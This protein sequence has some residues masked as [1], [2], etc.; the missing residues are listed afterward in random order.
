M[1]PSP[2]ALEPLRLAGVTRVSLAP[3]HTF[4]AFLFD[5]HRLALGSWAYAMEHA[6][7]EG[8]ATLLTFDRHF[9][10]VPPGQPANV[11]DRTAGFLALDAHARLQ[12]D[13]RNV[14]HIVAA[15]EAGL[16]GDVVALARSSPR[17]ALESD[18]WIDRRGKRH[19]ITRAPSLAEFLDV[20]GR[21]P[22]GPVLLDIDLD[23][24]TTLQE[25][26]PHDVLLWSRLQA[27]RLLVPEGCGDFWMDVL[28][29]TVAL[30]VALEP[31]HCGGITRGHVLFL[32]CGPAIFEELLGVGV[33]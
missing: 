6:R 9:D 8:P 14:D 23:A 28:P 33:P 20:G 29:R 4:E 10:L 16:V 32:E 27:R 3:R 2:E 21:L 19:A 24:F 13:V 31:Y 15:M 12:L 17:G 7:V 5:P 11:P 22:E 18:R 25:V 26:E 1:S 30:T